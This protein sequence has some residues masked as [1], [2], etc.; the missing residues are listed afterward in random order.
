LTTDTPLVAREVFDVGDTRRLSRRGTE[1]LP[2]IG[3]E[4]LG[5]DAGRDTTEN[6]YDRQRSRLQGR[7]LQ[8]S[9]RLALAER[10]SRRHG[11]RILGT[12]RQ[13][14][15]GDGARRAVHRSFDVPRHTGGGI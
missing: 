3:A 5:F 6:R 4:D 11:T 2:G 14:E 1:S 8:N 12:G 9:R 15:Y 10:I 7:C 13:P